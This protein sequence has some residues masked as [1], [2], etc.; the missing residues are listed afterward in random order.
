MVILRSQS[1]YYKGFFY[2]FRNISIYKIYKI[3]V[4]GNTSQSSWSPSR[5][6][7]THSYGYKLRSTD[8]V[9]RKILKALCKETQ[10]NHNG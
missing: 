1:S 5:P 10:N 9:S 2:R 6:P 7:K 8:S 4:Y 3:Y